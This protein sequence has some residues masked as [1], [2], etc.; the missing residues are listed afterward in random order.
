M[1]VWKIIWN[2]FGISKWIFI[3]EVIHL[4]TA[5]PHTGLKK[6]ALNVVLILT[7]RLVEKQATQ[8]LILVKRT[9]NQILTKLQR[10]TAPE[11]KI[12]LKDI[13][14]M[15]KDYWIN[16]SRLQLKLIGVN[17]IKFIGIS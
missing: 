16:Q 4:L 12:R 2:A 13:E 11:I 5:I 7:T 3:T 8:K 14:E 15:L 1:G 10:D 6:E 9:F 17:F